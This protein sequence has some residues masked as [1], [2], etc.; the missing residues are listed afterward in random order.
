[1]KYITPLLLFAFMVLPLTTYAGIHTPGTGLTNPE[2]KQATQLQI[3]DKTQD[4]DPIQAQDQLRLQD[5]TCTTTDCDPIQDRDR[6]RLM[7]Q[8]GTC[9]TTECE[10]I[11]DRDQTHLQDRIQDPTVLQS[12][13]DRLMAL[14]EQL[15]SLQAQM[16]H[17]GQ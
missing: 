14:L 15:Q 8:D 5:G 12:M 13:I 11:Q 6:D 10:P 3:Q 1:M 2:M 17:L 4:R 7:L 9:T 16:L